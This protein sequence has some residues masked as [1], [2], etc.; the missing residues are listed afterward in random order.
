MDL[1]LPKRKNN[2]FSELTEMQMVFLDNYIL[3]TT[4]PKVLFHTLLCPEKSERD[5]NSMMNS[6]LRNS[7]AEDYMKTRR[8]QLLNFFKGESV[9]GEDG[10]D[11]SVDQSEFRKMLMNKFMA[12]MKESISTGTLD[13]KQGAIVEKFV[14]KI[15][16]YDEREDNAPEPPCLYL[17]ENCLNC[18]YRIAIE[19]GENAI[20]ECKFCRYRKHCNENGIEYGPEDQLE[21][22]K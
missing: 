19:E 13:Y 22:E 11:D 2:K 1:A 7:D 17:P 8:Q 10:G 18:R 9:D 20:D 16:D 6:L 21:I 5:S 4:N 3:R 14:S 15:L 12:D